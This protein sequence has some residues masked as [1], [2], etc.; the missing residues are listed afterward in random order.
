M[1]ADEYKWPAP[2][3]ARN[4]DASVTVTW[5]SDPTKTYY[6][7]WVPSLA[8]GV[9]WYQIYYGPGQSGASSWTDDGSQTGSHPSSVDARF[10]RVRYSLP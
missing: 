6:V 1:G 3:I 2:T 8:S 4:P 7:A 9:T 10:Y 5:E